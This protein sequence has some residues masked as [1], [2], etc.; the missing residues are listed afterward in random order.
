MQSVRR[1]AVRVARV[2]VLALLVSVG[3]GLLA[4]VA[5]AAADIGTI[6]IASKNL[7]G[8]EVLSQ[9]YGQALA[10]QGAQVTFE[11]DVGPT[12][13][14]F[15]QL[16]E[17]AF[18]A[19]GEYQGT[20]LEFLGGT[21]TSDTE[22][23]HAALARRLEPLGLVVSEAAPAVDVNGFYV[24]RDTARKYKLTTVSQLAKVAPKLVF[25]GPP[26]CLDRPLCL[27]SKSE[28]LYRLRFKAIRK[29][30]TGGPESRAALVSGNVDVAIL[31]TGSSEIPKGAVLLRDDRGLQPADNPVLVLRREAATP[32]V[33]DVVDAVSAKVTTAAYRKMSLDVSVRHRD[34][35]DVAATFL[36]ANDLP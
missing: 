22:R 28:G 29:L 13:T 2:G 23:T 18:D 25:G 6:R 31:F 30:D 17:G 12:E 26:E 10:A 15:Q 19:Y 1:R 21:P 36:A 8:A 7:T 33:L 20:L 27:G 32:E 35:A 14:T 3:L 24:M 9:L 16:R 5:P 11:P 4:P 34:P